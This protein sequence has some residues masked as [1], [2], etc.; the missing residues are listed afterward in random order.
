M[1]YNIFERPAAAQEDDIDLMI[2]IGGL[3][4]TIYD[5]PAAPA[6]SKPALVRNI[7][8][9]IAAA[10]RGLNHTD[11]EAE[12]RAFCDYIIDPTLDRDGIDDLIADY[13]NTAERMVE[14][15]KTG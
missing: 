5:L 12:V 1:Y 2:V 4:R 7:R 10:S 14:E 11:A 9:A 8:E 15:G 6:C 13:I 3:A